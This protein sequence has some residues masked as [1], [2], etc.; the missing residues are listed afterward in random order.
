VNVFKQI[1]ISQHLHGLQHYFNLPK[2][3]EK[4]THGGLHGLWYN[5]MCQSCH[6]DGTQAKLR[7]VEQGESTENESDQPCES[8][9]VLKIK[10]LM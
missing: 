5:I 4:K 9:P 7:E 3:Q 8:S 1:L 10:L 6:G 2:E